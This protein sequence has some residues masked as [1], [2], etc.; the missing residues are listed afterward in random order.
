MTRQPTI[1]R[2]TALA[3]TAMAASGLLLNGHRTAHAEQPDAPLSEP[4]GCCLNAGTIRGFDL[5]LDEQIQVAADAGYSGYEPWVRD[6]QRYAEDGGDLADVKKLAEDRNVTI[7]GA[8]GFASWIVDDDER[9]AQGVEQLKRD[10]DLVR[11][12]GGAR[13][14]A[15]PAGANREP[16]TNLDA[17]AERYAAILDIGRDI[18]VL[19]MLEI[20][21]PSATLRKLGEAAYVVAQCGRRDAAL[22]LDSYHLYKGGN[23][24]EGLWQLNGQAMH[25]FH[26]NDYPANPP[27]EEIGDADRVFPGHGVCPLPEILQTL[28]ATGFRGG[29]SLELF[30]RT[31]WSEYPNAL[32]CAK[33][34]IEAIRDVVRQAMNG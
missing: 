20:W 34:G 13:I 24:F 2:R 14:A 21:G 31:Y 33:D 26:I 7:E 10:M 32:A 29:L 6:I 25:L 23:S 3:S 19:P 8:I 12:I 4:F 5:P 18:G 9:R 15:P 1:T 17:I 28:Y 16:L 27:R 11:Q 22:L 30:N